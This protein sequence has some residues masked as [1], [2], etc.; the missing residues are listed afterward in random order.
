MTNSEHEQEARVFRSFQVRYAPGA[1]GAFVMLGA[2]MPLLTDSFLLVVACWLW[3]GFMCYLQ[4][5]FSYL[6]LLKRWRLLV[7][8]V[9][10]A[11]TFVAPVLIHHFSRS[12]L[13]EF[14]A[15]M[16]IPVGSIAVGIFVYLVYSPGSLRREGW[17]EVED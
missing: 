4:R 13:L 7:F 2:F 1:F 12:P 8:V 15:A 3:V 17:V 14:I 10:V 5:P 6:L 16:V 11:V 9:L